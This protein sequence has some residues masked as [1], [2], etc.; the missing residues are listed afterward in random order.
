MLAAVDALLFYVVLALAGVA[1]GFINTMAGGGSMLTLPALMLLGLPADVANGSNRLSVVSQSVAGVLS[2]RRRGRLDTGALL[3]VVA[4]TTLGAVVGAATATQIPAQLL[5]YILLGTMMTMAV[6]ITLVP[7][8]LVAP[9][10]ATPASGRG[11]ILGMVGLFAAGLYGGFIQAGVGFLLLAALGGLMRY[12]LARA[13]ALKL[14]CVA[15]YGVAALGIFIAADQVA[16]VPAAVLA[17]ATII[18]SLIGVRFTLG[19]SQSVLRWIVLACVLATCGAAL[20]R[21]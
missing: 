9:T 16:W 10:D 6:V 7:K 11:R 17:V 2:F 20:L 15:V 5:E 13:N 19:V 3:P 12:D 21:G 8:A 18:G 1:S 14:A 4:P